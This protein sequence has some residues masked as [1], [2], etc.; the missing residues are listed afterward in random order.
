MTCSSQHPTRY[1]TDRVLVHLP[2]PP[3]NSPCP[4]PFLL[5]VVCLSVHPRISPNG[6]FPLFADPGGI[7]ACARLHSAR[8]RLKLKGL[9]CDGAP[10]A[11]LR[12][13]VVSVTKVKKKKKKKKKT[14]G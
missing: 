7:P 4:P 2:L 6:H 9:Y 10:S 11:L 5:P 13:H 12:A 3:G 1:D 14:L 8:H